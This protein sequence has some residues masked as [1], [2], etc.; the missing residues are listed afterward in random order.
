MGPVCPKDSR[1]TL[2]YTAQVGGVLLL[3]LAALASCGGV[4]EGVSGSMGGASGA[5]GGVDGFGGEPIASPSLPWALTEFPGLPDIAT[6]VP[7]SRVA[8]GNLLFFD[9]VLSID[10]ETACGT[11]HSEFWGMSDGIPVGVGHGAGPAAGPG[12]NGPNVSR[13]NSLALFNL[14][15][16]E[17]LLWDGRS[18]SLEDQA[19]LPLLSEVELN[20]DP[21]T[22][23]ERLTAIPEYVDLFAAAFPEDPRVTVDN[24]A[25]AIAAFERTFV[26]DRSIY[27]AYVRGHLGAF[28]DELVEGMFLFAQMGCS[29]CHAPPLFE[30]EV[31][32]DRNVP[33]VDGVEDEGL[34]EA[35]GLPEDIG[36]FRTPSLRNAIVTEPYFHNGAVESLSDAV[37]HEL[38]RS[39]M[40]FT[41]DEVRLIERFISKGLRDESRASSRPLSVPSGLQVPL[42]GQQFPFL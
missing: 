9:P 17:T 19:I 38:E 37:E 26:S 32:A 34:A 13:R 14:A 28:D 24:L 8:L 4:S 11:C 30:S 5:G 29:D 21:D 36:K 10:G 42:D 2:R 6:E 7:A 15:F 23:I 39:G 27:D 3:T 18:G 1:C 33:D 20:L 35:T 12:R 16:R 41:D 40:P 25:A 31:F 22:A